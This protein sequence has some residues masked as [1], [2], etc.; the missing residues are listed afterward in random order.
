MG[1]RSPAMARL[2]VAALLAAFSVSGALAS[3]PGPTAAA[4]SSPQINKPVTP[5]ANSQSQPST[6]SFLDIDL[7][8]HP[9][10]VLLPVGGDGCSTVEYWPDANAAN[11]QRAAWASQ[12][13]FGACRFGLTHGK[14]L[15]NDG[16][17]KWREVNYLYG[18]ELKIT[19]D[20]GIDYD[21]FI[22][23]QFFGDPKTVEASF[24]KL[25]LYYVGRS[26]P[27]YLP[28][29]WKV[30]SSITLTLAGTKSEF[31]DSVNH[32]CPSPV[33]AV[34]K[35]FAS[36]IKRACN[37]NKSGD[38]LLLRRHDLS[39]PANSV[40]KDVTGCPFDEKKGIIDCAS[41][42]P[43]F[44]GPLR[45]RLDRILLNDVPSRAAARDELIRSYAPLELALAANMDRL[46]GSRGG[47]L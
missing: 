5:A 29:N 32:N 45:A 22:E 4:N 27:T 37:S 21:H 46:Q 35:A 14:G 28:S 41:V 47:G 38:I 1:Y 42:L 25:S 24:E 8:L 16:R 34:Y 23:M 13:W 9:G 36:D 19:R 2:C 40:F 33:P 3:T 30:G 31:I 20:D 15:L 7:P 10:E 12:K 44:L 6:S 43:D 17:G 11:A 39:K 26:E 18:R